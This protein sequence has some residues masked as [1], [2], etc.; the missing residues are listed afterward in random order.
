MKLS[1]T[2]HSEG[3][4]GTMSRSHNQLPI[5]RWDDVLSILIPLEE[6]TLS[7]HALIEHIRAI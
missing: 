5:P 3:D 4:S 1:S 6:T 2:F 7:S